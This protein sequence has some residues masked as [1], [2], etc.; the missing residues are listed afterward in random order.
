MPCGSP[1]F[2]N[3]LQ[4]KTGIATDWFRCLALHLM[5]KELGESATLAVDRSTSGDHVARGRTVA[6]INPIGVDG[7]ERARDGC[8]LLLAARETG[9]AER[10][11]QH[12]NGVS[13]VLQFFV[14]SN[15][16]A[17]Q[18]DDDA[19]D[20]DGED[21]NELG[22]DDHTRFVIPELCHVSIAFAKVD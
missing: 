4:M 10:L 7:A 17:A 5:M 6:V 11:V 18:P 1:D 2:Q 8:T 14:D 22:R 21:E 13:G 9:D 12:A 3:H 15:N 16:H 19:E 20:T